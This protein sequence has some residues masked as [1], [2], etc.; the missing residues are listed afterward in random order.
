M[1]CTID[2]LLIPYA[3]QPLTSFA[4]SHFAISARSFLVSILSGS[5]MMIRDI[6][7]TSCG[8]AALTVL[9][10][11]HTVSPINRTYKNIFTLLGW[12]RVALPGA[13]PLKCPGGVLIW[14][15]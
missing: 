13:A 5:L 15:P 8:Y 6:M 1:N 2:N 14:T 3:R 7:I 12:G 10:V 11:Y 4:R 9:I